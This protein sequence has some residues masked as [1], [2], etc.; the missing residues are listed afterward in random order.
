MTS[1]TY[2]ALWAFFVFCCCWT[3]YMYW[4]VDPEWAWP[5]MPGLLF[6]TIT[7]CMVEK[8][9]YRRMAAVRK[10]K[11]DVIWNAWLEK[12]ASY[13]RELDEDGC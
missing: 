6:S 10:A 3:V 7:W 1:R 2:Y 12:N 9:L 4:T 8:E 11:Q 5:M 13:L